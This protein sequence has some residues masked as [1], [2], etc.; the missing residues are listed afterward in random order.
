V[1]ELVK[2]RISVASSLSSGM[3]DQPLL[4]S[5]INLGSTARLFAERVQDLS[6]R[7]RF[8]IHLI[9]DNLCRLGFLTRIGF[10]KK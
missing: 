7:D 9:V 6:L 8:E 10:D 2:I 1:L 3:R 5:L 4:L